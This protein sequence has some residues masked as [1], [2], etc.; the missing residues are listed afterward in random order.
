MTILILGLA[1]F[2]GIHSARIVAAG[3]RLAF[4]DAR[5]ADTWKGFYTIVSL[6]GFALLVWGYGL[7]REDAGQA[8]VPP[9]WG[10]TAQ[11]VL[12][13]VALILVV[14]SQ[15]PAGRIK[16]ALRHPML[17]GVVIWAATHLA[18]NGDWA[19]LLLFGAFLAWG[20]M[21]LVSCYRRPRDNPH[22]ADGGAT[23]AWWPD[24]AAIVIGVV[25][26][27]AFVSFLH[28]W[29]FGVSPIV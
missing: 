20:V 11:H 9:D 12:M 13:P 8:Y 15:L 2:L 1:L 3:Q 19:S 21:D 5:G 10:R 27:W 22:A 4:I 18:G 7:Y 24:V 28:E 16:R 14:A 26:T 6:A 17:W 23:T 29:L 25:L